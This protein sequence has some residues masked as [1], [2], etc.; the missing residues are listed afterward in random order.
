MGLF[1][2]DGRHP[3]FVTLL[4]DDPAVLTPEHSDVLR[5]LRPLLARALDRLPSLAALSRLL[6]D[7]LGAV[8]LI[9]G[10][11]ACPFPVCPST[12]FSLR[13]RRS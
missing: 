5:R 12:R 2:E 1:A 9:R 13:T 6:G 7:A 10:G 3:G 8:V 4:S 11:G